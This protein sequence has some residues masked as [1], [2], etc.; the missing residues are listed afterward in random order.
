MLPFYPKGVQNGISDIV[1]VETLHWHLLKS[2]FILKKLLQ[3][4]RELRRKQISSLFIDVYRCRL[5]KL[6]I[7]TTHKTITVNG[8]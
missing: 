8:K 4:L 3:W 1:L 6:S 5:D 7:A 2:H